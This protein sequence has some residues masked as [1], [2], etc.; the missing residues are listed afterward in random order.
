MNLINVQHSHV[1]IVDQRIDTF[2]STD[3][4]SF[5]VAWQRQVD[6]FDRKEKKRW[7]VVS[8]AVTPMLIQPSQIATAPTAVI[9][10]TIVSRLRKV[11]PVVSELDY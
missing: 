4:H 11:L 9:C 2:I 6:E 1:E 10:L 3:L 7:Y 5:T 8:H